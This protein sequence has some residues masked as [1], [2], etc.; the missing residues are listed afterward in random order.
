MCQM[1]FNQSSAKVYDVITQKLE[2]ISY[3]DKKS[4][5]LMDVQ[6]VKLDNHYQTPLPLRTPVMKLSNNRKMVKRRAQYFKKRFEKNS[7]YFFQCKELMQE[8][9]SK[10]YAKI[11]IDTP[12]DLRIWHLSD[13]GI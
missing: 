4:L 5:K 2:D 6:T 1:E 8:I 7:K 13:H 11:S 3:E 10:G 12:T 9:L